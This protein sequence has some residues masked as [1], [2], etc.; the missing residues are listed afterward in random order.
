MLAW[1]RAPGNVESYHGEGDCA[2]VDLKQEDLGSMADD[3]ARA[4]KYRLVWL[5]SSVRIQMRARGSAY[6]KEKELDDRWQ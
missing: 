5:K 4:T 2:I 6:L 1:C 3:S